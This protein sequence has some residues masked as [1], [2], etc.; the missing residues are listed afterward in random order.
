MKKY[1]SIT[2]FLLLMT[3]GMSHGMIQESN[4]LK[5]I[6]EKK[7]SKLLYDVHQRVQY[8]LTSNT[9][10]E[11]HPLTREQKKKQI[12]L[13]KLLNIDK[14]SVK[15]ESGGFYYRGGGRVDGNILNIDQ[16]F[17]LIPYLLSHTP[18]KNKFN[19][20]LDDLSKL[21]KKYKKQQKEQ[22]VLTKWINIYADQKKRY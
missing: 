13:I 3:A 16:K 18:K 2:T 1:L 17:C 22:R 21:E 11:K 14:N 4:T 7:D 12:K 6:Q 10:I 15:E 8:A 20:L 5:K 19:K 9:K